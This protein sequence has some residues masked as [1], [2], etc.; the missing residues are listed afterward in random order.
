MR[1]G[2]VDEDEGIGVASL[3]RRRSQCAERRS[4]ARPQRVD[5]LHRGARGVTIRML[6]PSEAEADVAWMTRA[7]TAP[8]VRANKRSGKEPPDV[9]R[10]PWTC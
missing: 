7:S 1:A 9:R 8:A 6:E 2:L 3:A 10:S 5:E 4:D